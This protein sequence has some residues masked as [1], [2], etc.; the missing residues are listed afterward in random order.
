MNIIYIFAYQAMPDGS[1]SP[2]TKR[3]CL[4]AIKLHQNIGGKFLIMNSYKTVGITAAES[5]SSYLLSQGVDD[6]DIIAKPLGVNTI[7]EIKELAQWVSSQ[8]EPHTL[9]TISS[10]YHAPRIR[11]YLKQ[12]GLTSKHHSEYGGPYLKDAIHEPRKILRDLF[13]SKARSA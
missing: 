13:H 5:M 12:Y 7:A 8:E 10:W 3:R 6:K 1:C 2:Q 4:R 9:H 11:L